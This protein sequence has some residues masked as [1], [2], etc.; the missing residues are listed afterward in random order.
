ML[1]L[2]APGVLQNGR[3]A[4]EHIA[5]VVG[6]QIAPLEPSET[7]ARTL[8]TDILADLPVMEFGFDDLPGP[9]FHVSDPQAEPLGRWNHSGTVA[10][11]RKSCGDR[12][13][14]YSAGGKLPPGVLRALARQAG[15]HIY[16]ETDDPL[17][18]N[19]HLLG[20]HVPRNEDVRLSLP[21]DA[22]L[23]EVFTGEVLRTTDGLLHVRSARQAKLFALR[24]PGTLGP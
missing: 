17:Y 16:L 12:N 21:R 5:E 9:A 18:A 1:W 2:S 15:A 4:P 6:M 14:F 24:S 11:A 20:L 13:V 22:E 8:K 10:L 23:Q 7:R 19:S 3:L